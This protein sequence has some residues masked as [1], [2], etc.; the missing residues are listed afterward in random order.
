MA[1]SSSRST[2]TMACSARERRANSAAVRPMRA[3]AVPDGEWP[4]SGT[5]SAAGATINLLMALLR[6]A[7][8]LPCPVASGGR[9]G[10]IWPALRAGRRRDPVFSSPR[11]GPGP[12]N[13]RF[14]PNREVK[15]LQIPGQPGRSQS[16]MQSLNSSGKREALAGVGM[17]AAR[18]RDRRAGVLLEELSA[19][20]APV[21]LRDRRQDLREVPR[22]AV[23]LAL[24]GR[25]QV[26]GLVDV[27]LDHP[28]GITPMGSPASG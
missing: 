9:S 18:A 25:D 10:A 14:P 22:L 24:L 13:R 23:G 17:A 28:H 2:S 20:Q 11:T 12:K 27:F 15:R 16:L 4:V 8:V 19:R 5:D 7:G 26:A 6:E 3:I 1:L 21:V